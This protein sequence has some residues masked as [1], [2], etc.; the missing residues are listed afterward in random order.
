MRDLIDLREVIESIVPFGKAIGWIARRVSGLAAA[1]LCVVIETLRP[2]PS[3]TTSHWPPKND[4]EWAGWQA[5]MSEAMDSRQ[6]EDGGD[7]S[8]TSSSETDGGI[9]IDLGKSKSKMSREN[10]LGLSSDECAPDVDS[11]AS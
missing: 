2:K 7:L 8:R 10:M 5:R 4:E 6:P 3:V 1:G 9:K 11:A